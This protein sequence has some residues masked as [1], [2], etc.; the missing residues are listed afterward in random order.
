MTSTIGC[1]LDHCF[2]ATITVPMTIT[3]IITISITITIYITIIIIISSLYSICMHTVTCSGTGPPVLVWEGEIQAA[4][5]AVKNAENQ[6]LMRCRLLAKPGT[7]PPAFDLGWSH[8]LVKH[9]AAHTYPTA[10]CIS[11]HDYSCSAVAVASQ[12]SRF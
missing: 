10:T 12:F 3:T 1:Y 7:W 2:I 11:K 8:P 9:S 5:S 4:G 6:H